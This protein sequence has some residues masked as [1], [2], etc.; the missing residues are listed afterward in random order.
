MHIKCIL[1]VYIYIKCLQI[2]C[3][4][5]LLNASVA[6]C[7]R[8]GAPTGVLLQ[9]PEDSKCFRYNPSDHGEGPP[10]RREAGELTEESGECELEVSL[11]SSEGVLLDGMLLKL[12]FATWR[13]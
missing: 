10:G 4:V 11:A 12:F 5:Y 13:G 7:A 8:T 3:I 1:N 9:I 6:V 2:K